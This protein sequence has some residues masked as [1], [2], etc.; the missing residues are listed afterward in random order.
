M[1]IIVKNDSLLLDYLY[2]NITGSKNNIKSLLKTGI[3]VNDKKTSQYDYPIKKGDILNIS[4]MVNNLDIIYE[5][6][7]FIVINKPSGI[8]SIGTEKEK[9]KTLYHMVLEYLKKKNQKVFIVH[10]LDKD[11]SGVMVFSKNEKLKMLLQNN[12]NNLVKLREYKAIV[13]GNINQEGIF[14]SYL[15]ENKNHMVYS[16]DKGKLALTKYKKIKTNKKY[17]LVD[18]EIKT[19][20]KNQIRVQFADA[21]YPIIGDSKYGTKSNRLYLHASK[22]I[23]INPLN[24]KQMIFETGLPDEFNKLI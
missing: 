14:K 24:R 12:W 11:T 6:K 10:R 8:L 1:K 9:E 22:I 3:F 17:S 21:G 4:K 19:G 15:E 20:R 16:S 23:L 5:D 7:D 13:K 2:Q 18:I